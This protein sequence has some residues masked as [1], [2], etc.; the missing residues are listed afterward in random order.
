MTIL[1]FNFFKTAQGDFYLP[2]PMTLIS[3]VSRPSRRVR[4]APLCYSWILCSS[5]RPSRKS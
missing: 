4:S 2:E 3:S 5:K 1:C